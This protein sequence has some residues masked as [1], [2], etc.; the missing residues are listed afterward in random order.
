MP[1]L[2]VR[3]RASQ[4]ILLCALPGMLAAQSPSRH[5]PTADTLFPTLA[6]EVAQASGHGIDYL[7]LRDRAARR[8]TAAMRVLFELSARH[9]FDGAGADDHCA[10][11]WAL[12]AR[13]GDARYAAVLARQRLGVRRAVHADLEY[14]G[15]SKFARRFP[16]TYAL[17][18]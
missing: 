18:T 3:V 17:G 14:T 12:L 15:G 1:Y 16:R 6:E 2:E 10:T 4:I 11:L 5:A 9:I 7:K 13:W 8:D